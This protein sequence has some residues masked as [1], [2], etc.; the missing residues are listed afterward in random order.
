M[1]DGLL[2]ALAPS[3][4]CSIDFGADA[5][6]AF[7][8]YETDYC[9][10]VRRAGH[11]V[12]VVHVDYVHED[13]GGV[14]DSDAFERGAAILLD[15]WPQSI[16]PLTPLQRAWLSTRESKARGGSVRHRTLVRPKGLR[17]RG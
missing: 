1:V 8:G 9:L 13:K 4:L 5:L 7:H 2:L 12:R 17:R 11:R 16:V 14:G 6:P 3:A 10:L 15:R